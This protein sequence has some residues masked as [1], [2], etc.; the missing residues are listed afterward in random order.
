MWVH[1]TYMT[2]TDNVRTLT[3]TRILLR[4]WSCLSW[5]VKK[6]YLYS[7]YSITCT[8]THLCCHDQ[9]SNNY[10]GSRFFQQQTRQKQTPIRNSVSEV[11]DDNSEAIN[12]CSFSM[13]TCILAPTRTASVMN[14]ASP[15]TARKMFCRRK[16]EHLSKPFLFC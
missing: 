12:F 10:H 6:K 13:K 14:L 4:Y 5:V 11:V 1:T 7:L 16:E 15:L 9:K 2:D 8:F 3:K